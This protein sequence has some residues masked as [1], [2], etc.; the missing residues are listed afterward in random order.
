MLET[1]LVSGV[2]SSICVFK[3]TDLNCHEADGYMTKLS[4]LSI[5]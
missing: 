3:Y 4:G 5:G 1:G 2:T